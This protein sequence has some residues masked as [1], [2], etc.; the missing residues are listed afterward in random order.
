MSFFADGQALIWKVWRTALPITGWGRSKLALSL[1]GLIL[2]A[3]TL[4]GSTHYDLSPL[5]SHAY[6]MV[7]VADPYRHAELGARDAF[8]YSPVVAQLLGP[9]TKLPFDLFQLLL[10]ATSLGALTACCGTYTLLVPGVI[11]DLV[12]G[13]IHILLAA[14]VVVGFRVPGVWAAALLTKVTPGIGLVWFAVRREWGALAQVATVTLLIVAA[15]VAVGGVEVWLDW[16]KLLGANA[17]STYTYKLWN[18]G[19]FTP[20]SLLVRL[21]IALLLVSW[22]A[23]GGRRWTVPLA[24]LLALPVIWPSSLAL[25]A[26]VPPL[27]IGDR[28]RHTDDLLASSLERDPGVRLEASTR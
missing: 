11:E 2:L 4:S 22:G 18:L 19:N 20:P 6:W 8:L 28:R 9:L 24:A 13:N 7:N 16:L 26:A 17:G 5:D 23:R 1:I 3:L 14:V 10:R 27:W 12:R 15:S 21:P 25:L